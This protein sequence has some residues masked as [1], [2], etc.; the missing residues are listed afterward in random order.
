[1]RIL[2]YNDLD[3]RQIPGFAKMV[4]YLEADDFKSA[5]VKKICTGPG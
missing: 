3:T 5:K 2:L 4:N 1:M